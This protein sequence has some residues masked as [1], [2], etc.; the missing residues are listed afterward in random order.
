LRAEVEAPFCLGL[1]PESG[2]AGG[3]IVFAGPPEE[4]VKGKRSYTG[5]FLRPTLAR[6]MAEGAR[7]AAAGRRKK[8]A[9]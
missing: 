6:K 5:R 4:I 9:G 1:G 2:D 3:E 7:D 8:A